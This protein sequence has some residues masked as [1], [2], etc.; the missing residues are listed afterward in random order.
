[1]AVLSW[2]TGCRLACGSSLPSP[3]LFTAQIPPV[4]GSMA[5]HSLSGHLAATTE[6]APVVVGALPLDSWDLHQP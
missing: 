4:A 3:F 5:E 6:R 1:M 2:G